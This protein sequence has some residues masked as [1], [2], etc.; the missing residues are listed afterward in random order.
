[1]SPLLGFSIA[2]VDVD[3]G[4]SPDE[5]EAGAAALTRQAIEHFGPRWGVLFTYRAATKD[6]P[7][8]SNEWVMLLHLQPTMDGALGY[9][10]ETPF[11]L[12]QL[13]V[14]VGLCKQL[15]VPWTTTAGH[16][17]MEAAAD[18]FLRRCV[19]NQA[20]G[21]IWALEVC[22]AVE[23]G[24]YLIDGV[25]M[26]NFCTPEWFEPPT[27]LAGVK[28]D[29][30]GQ[31]SSPFQIMDGGYGQTF[32]SQKGWVQHQPAARSEYREVLAQ[33]GVSR[34]ERRKAP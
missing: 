1:M 26:S 11:G 32:D 33:A 30:M 5:I 3:S 14:F 16:E 27:T 28:F 13:H 12:P 20:D 23:Q 7:A 31:C 24:T 4:L 9:H 10:D 19:Q 29:Y 15:G 8:G 21:S 25:P 2:L 34:G 18:P 22:D 17:G 6:K